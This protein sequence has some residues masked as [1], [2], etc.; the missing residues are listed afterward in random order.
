MV[1]P[2]KL[3]LYILATPLLTTPNTQLPKESRLITP[4]QVKLVSILS[5]PPQSFVIK[6]EF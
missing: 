3:L 1:W 2:D 4:L 5:T 6:L